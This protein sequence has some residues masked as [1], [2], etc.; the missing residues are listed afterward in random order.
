MTTVLFCFILLLRKGY[1]SA[2][3]VLDHISATRIRI[4]NKII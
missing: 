2:V 1:D 3:P 4:Q